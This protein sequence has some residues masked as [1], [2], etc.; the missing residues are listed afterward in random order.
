MHLAPGLFL[1]RPAPQSVSPGFTGRT[2][3]RG[4]KRPRKA[5]ALNLK[6]SAE[7]ATSPL[8]RTSSSYCGLPEGPGPRP[9]AP[10][11]TRPAHTHVG[12]SFSEVAQAST[13]RISSVEEPTQQQRARFC[14]EA[15]TKQ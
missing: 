7:S 15:R 5:Y 13:W 8:T 2:R 6:H 12:V 4:K 3:Q 10:S 11:R 9:R 14:K 1:W